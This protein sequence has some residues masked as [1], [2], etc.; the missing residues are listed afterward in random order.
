MENIKEF[1][2]Y[3]SYVPYISMALKKLGIEEYRLNCN[4]DRCIVS[5]NLSKRN[6][7]VLLR[8][9]WAAKMTDEQGVRYLTRED[10]NKESS[11]VIPESESIFFERAWL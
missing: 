1:N 3:K 7:K 2:I 4:G 9:A 8:N 10:I 11:G 6:F 5:A